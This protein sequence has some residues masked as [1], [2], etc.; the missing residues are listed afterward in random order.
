MPYPEEAEGFQ[1]DSPD[2][3]T[4]FHKRYFP[5][6]PFGD[7]DVDVK[8]EACGICGSDVHIISGG[9]GKQHFPLCVGHEIVGTAIRV[10]PKVTLIKEG[11]RVGVGAQ[12]FS[13]GECKQCK[14]DNETYCQ[15]KLIDTYGSKWPETGLVSQGGYASHIRVHEWWV[16][17][18]PEKLETTI[19]APMLC[20]GITVFS[21]LVRNGCGPGKKVG[22]VGIGGLGHF[23]LQFAKALGAEVWA[24]SRTRAKEEDARK[25]GA[26]G[27]IA[28]AEEGWEKPHRCTF[29]LIVNAANSTKNFD[30][31]KY[32]SMMDVHG[33]W[34][35]VGL[36]EEEGQ[37]IKAQHLISNGVLIGATH[38]GSRREMLQM[39]QL[40]AD[41]NLK[42][43][44]EEVQINEENLAVAVQRMKK[45]DVRYRM[46][47]TGYDKVFGN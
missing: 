31:A 9:W 8:I 34:I 27:F 28:T 14:N 21:P 25:L 22:I 32:L 17:P 2:S 37:V 46:T 23:G 42:A 29:D 47:L 13:C 18:I 38:L 24:I 7:Y 5:L 1:V 3:W 40:A 43:W 30:L 36:P 11:Q 33:H 35:N 15:Y 16:F 39:L 19:V 45:G 41:K 12:V 44:A 4:T 6:N 20:A 26:D 10:G